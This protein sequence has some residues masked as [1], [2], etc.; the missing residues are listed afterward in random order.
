M[1]ISR[2]KQGINVSQRK[3]TLDL[4]QETG[5][6]GAKPAE[7][8][9]ETNCNLEYKKD[10]TPVDTRRYQRLV[11]K[12]IYLAHTRPD[13]S[14]AVG[15]DKRS[16]TGYITY[17]WGNMVT[18]RSKK[19][20]VVS[21]SSAEAELRALALGVCEGIWIIRVLKELRLMHIGSIKL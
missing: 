18:S 11:G 10:G 3:Y 21:R 7:T 2:T 6:L 12:L 16:I 9:M 14:Y 8:P 4:L 20:P 17:L 13:I 15:V 19:Q 1:E 5:M